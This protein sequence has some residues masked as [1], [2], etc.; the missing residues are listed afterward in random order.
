MELSRNL[1]TDSVRR[2]LPTAARRVD[3]GKPVADAVDALREYRVGC[4]LVTH[5]EKLVGVFTDRDLLARVL[6][7]GLPLHTPL[8][9]CMTAGPVTVGPR[10]SVRTALQRMQAGGYR[11]LP[12]TDEAG[13]PV[14]ILSAK[15]IVRYIVEHFP[16]VVFTQPP[17]AGGPGGRY[18]A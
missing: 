13:R 6:A 9:E 12:V 4:L 15:R 11:H 5:A 2:L 1:A 16:A 3:A 7:V 17:A 8:R 10:D 18:G 14:G